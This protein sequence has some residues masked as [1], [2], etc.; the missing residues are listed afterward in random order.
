M[1]AS[2]A[3]RTKVDGAAGRRWTRISEA[4]VR[5]LLL[6]ILGAATSVLA[7]AAAAA[8]PAPGSAAAPISMEAYAGP[9]RLVTLPDRRRINLRCMGHGSPTVLL[10]A[11][12]GAWS[13]AWNKVQPAIARTTR[14][15]AYDRAGYGFS[16]PGP[17]PR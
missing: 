2:D 17:L 4:R 7:S 9:G 14:V 10:E 1:A 13:F 15:C 16:S 3:R 5:T 11:G 6:A 12:F 8:A